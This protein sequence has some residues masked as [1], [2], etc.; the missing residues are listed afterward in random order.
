MNNLK[1]KDQTTNINFF[2]S[3]SFRLLILVIFVVAIAVLTNLISADSE[4]SRAVSSVN[5]N[6]I[7][8]IAETAAELVENAGE[9]TADPSVYSELLSNVKM[10]GVDSSY[11]YLVSSDGT[12]L[13]H[14]TADKIGQ[15]VENAVVSGVVEELK[16]GNVPQHT[17]VLYDFKGSK[18]Y[19]AYALTQDQKILVVTADQA[20]I[21][22][23]I[24]S[25]IR[26]MGVISVTIM[27]FCIIFGY[28]FSL[29][30]CSPIKKLTDIIIDTANLNFRHNPASRKLCARKD[31]T[32]AMAREI[33]IMRKNLRQMI[34][35]I[36]SASVQITGNVNDLQ[37][38]TDTVDNMCSDNSA[39]SQQL[40]AGMEETAATTA[41][42]NENIDSIRNNAEKINQMATE[43]A[44]TSEEIMTRAK[45]L[46][47]KTV[48]ASSKTMDMYQNVKIKA[49]QA[50]EGSK[51]VEKINELTQTIMAIS[52]QT[53]LLALN[54]SIEAARAGE[55]GRG[56]AVVATEIGGLA[57][58]TSKA[59][60]DIGAII[61]E[62]NLAVGNM[63]DCLEETTGFLENTVVTEYKEFEQ[64]SVQ[65]QDDANIFKTNMDR[66]KNSMTQL[67][68]S[69]DA[70]ATA[71]D[72][73]N[74]TVN[75]S[76]QGVVDIAE[77][78]SNMVE[79]TGTTHDMVSECY[80]CLENLKGI[81]NRFTL[82]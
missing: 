78:T 60:S 59:I 54:A 65:Y 47:T 75:E 6:Y 36:D 56:F 7:L 19:A 67:S 42:I 51:A 4:A 64:V 24:D 43:G 68:D 57:D 26:K 18:K 14:P 30:I 1:E 41:T 79:K 32:G 17:V 71:L 53:S 58:Q 44:Q 82:E 33:R 3:I 81:V 5:E 35:D 38:I 37:S 50:I 13:Y 8:S 46:R 2:H 73:I 25:M 74:N 39:T 76:S 52:S 40:A 9:G 10:E 21:M 62:V 12:M 23:P 77:K 48:T 20:E 11:A 49:D 34:T 22:T 70:I 28:I 72:G 31:E 55:A 16:S 66:V 15:P 61:N 80:G 45:N 29:F 27:I 63:S 69:I